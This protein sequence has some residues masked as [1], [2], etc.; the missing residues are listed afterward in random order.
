MRRWRGIWLAAALVL[1]TG[2]AEAAPT[3]TT[4]PAS[5]IA[6][7]G[8]TL[9]GTVTSRNN[10]S[11]TVTFDYG[12]TTSY[13]SSVDYPSNPLS[14]WA[15]D[16]PVSADVSGLT[17]NTTYHYR[18]VGAGWGTTYGNDVTFT[19]SACPP[20]TVTTNAASDLS[21]TGATLNGTVSSNGAA[22]TVNFDY[23]T[24]ASYGSSVSYA[25][26]P[27]ADSAS[28]ASVLA[29]VTGL[30]C[31]T[32]YHYRVRATNSGGTTNGADGTFTTVAC[33]TAVTLAKTASSSAAIVNSYVSFTIDA[34]NETG[35]PLSNV[36]VTDVLPTGMTYSAASASLG[37]TAVAGQTLTWTIPS[38]PAG[39]NAQ[40]TVVVNLTQ[41][42]SIT[43]TVTSPG[44]TSASATILVLP[45]AITTYRMDETAG[46]WNG[47]T[48]EVIDSGG[49][50]LHGRRRQ[51][52]TTTTNTVSPTP[53][54]ASQHPSVNGG[55]CNAGSFDG[56]AVVESASSSY[57]QFTNVM[58]ASA[59]IYPTAY[60]TSDLYSILSNDV[61]YEFHLNTGGRLFWWWQASTLTSA[62]TIPLNQWTHIAITMDSTPGNRR[63]RIYINGVQDANTNNWT[64]TLATNSCPFYIGGDIG[65][66]SG[67]ALIPGRNFRGMIDEASIYDYE[68]T[69]AEVQA[70]M[71]LGRQCSGTFHH[72]EIVHDG[73]ASVCASKT[74]TLKAC[75]DAGCTVLYPGAVSVQL[76]PTG[77]TPSDTVNFSG[78]VATATLSNS[79]LTAPSV[80]LGT[81][82]ITPAPSSPT[83]C[84]NGSTYDCTLNVAS[85]SCLADAVEVGASPYTNLY[86][87][88]AGTAFN[89][90][91]L[92]IDAG[93]VNTV[94]T[95]TMH[96]DLVDADTG[97][98]AGSTALNAAQSV[99]FAAADLGRKTI[100]MTSPVAHR[101]AQ[102][103][104]RLGSQYACSADRFAIRPT[105]LTIASNMNANAAG[106]DAAAM[107]TLAAGNAFTL[108]AT[109][110]AGYDGT[111]TIVAG[112]VAA[113][114]GAAAT[115]TLTGSFSAANPATGI[116]S[117]SSFAYG[118]VGYFRFATD[119]VVDTGFTLVDQP[120][121][122]IN[123]TPNDFSN[124]LVGGR[125]G[126]KFGNTA[127][128]SYFGRFIPHHFDTTLTQGCVVAAPLTSFTYS[129]QP[130][131]LTVTA[132]NLAGA[133]T[134]NYQGSFAKT[135]TLTDANAVA[136][137][138][139]SPATI[140]SAS[141]GTG[142][143][144]L[145][146]SAASPPVYTFAHATPD[147][148]PATIALRAVDTDGATSETGT[149]GTAL[150]RMGRLRLSN[151]YG[152]MSPLAMP[153]A[154]QYWTGNSW[155]TNGDDNCTAIAT[156][157]VGNSAAGWTPTG[158][159]TLA[160]GAGTISLVP[161][162]PGT[163]TVCADLAVDPA[164]GVVCAATSAA[165]P[166][167]QSKWPPGANYD[168]DPSA[169][170]SFGVFS[171]ESRRGIYNREMY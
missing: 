97:C 73:S 84:Y 113:H 49:N 2:A 160:A 169:T 3:V 55:F 36:V 115:G 114:G 125:Y 153:V 7:G 88:L 4:D 170:A 106:T 127:N 12:T 102:V 144:T 43:N 85:S 161:D 148:A 60:P 33:P 94:Y 80:M 164:V 16:Q 81:V 37:S 72:I 68:M 59:W 163:A 40:L 159:G 92:A 20:P 154:A 168:N 21:A 98:T 18:V 27:L 108:T 142:A 48:G 53:T 135:A 77:W 138:A 167:L 112:N 70:A 24:T 93:A 145:L 52:A 26:N 143:A 51:S 38:L 103:R 76:S 83:V 111:P 34:I 79:A 9:N 109:G 140:A 89:L 82:G 41:T 22:T 65:T 157:N 17:C 149:E 15:T 57:F 130:F 126:C 118:E 136:G 30:T 139:L 45:G 46:S 31:N 71:R 150:I 28:N 120:N 128:T 171:P 116:A 67:C 152:S 134:Q 35:L 42:G 86:T 155:V 129:A 119:G 75:L 133:T 10:R 87:K 121:D 39:Y 11:T 162:A 74:V 62:A 64:G 110:V 151:V 66:N 29:A 131:D 107:P 25:S 23:G 14:R 95:G 96:A 105:G 47:T 141:F 104:I 158:P 13:G 6:A 1:L 156:A 63:Q 69:A 91:V 147:P 32:L 90:D 165:L 122:C 54:I 99:H 124:A 44:A 61:N 5:G 8:A 146:R 19:T 100:T 132:R 56:N 101:R 58:S 166:W 78:G 123:T 50:N 137:G 117:G